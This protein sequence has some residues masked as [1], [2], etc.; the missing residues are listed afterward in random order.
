[1]IEK[2]NLKELYR[3][4][5]V[6]RQQIQKYRDIWLKKEEGKFNNK[7]EKG[8]K[9]LELKKEQVVQELLDYFLEKSLYSIKNE[10]ENY[11][12]DYS[13]PLEY[14]DEKDDNYT[15]QYLYSIPIVESI[16]STYI[17]I[18]KNFWKNFIQK[19]QVKDLNIYAFNMFYFNVKEEIK[20]YFENKKDE[21]EK[22]LDYRNVKGSGA[23]LDPK[24][25]E[26]LMLKSVDDYEN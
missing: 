18:I 1:L 20:S 3:V 14:Y 26:R 16:I 8:R 5:F 24:R 7:L 11:I 9:E 13:Y 25:F 2:Y 10:I 22:L 15:E 12:L 4:Y 17:F 19:K 6:D 21:I 23:Y